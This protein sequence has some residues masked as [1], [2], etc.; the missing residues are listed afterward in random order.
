MSP[1][2][3]RPPLPPGR[4]VDLPGRGTTFVRDQA[5]PPGAPT[6]LLLHGWTASA[7]LNWCTAYP[8]LGRRWRVVALDHRGHGRG[9]R[10]Q[11][12]FTL[13]DCADDAAALVAAMGL[14]R[15][16]AV[17]YSMGG[18]VAQLLWRRHPDL[19]EGLVLCSTSAHFSETSRERVLFSVLGAT[20][21]IARVTSDARRARIA[22]RFMEGRAGASILREW[23]VAELQ[24]HDWLR[25]VEAGRAIGRFSSREWVASIDVPTSVLVTTQDTVVP[26]P[27]QLELAAAIPRT[28]LHTIDAD[29]GVCLRRPQLFV[30]ALVA[31]VASVAA[32]PSSRPLASAA[33]SNSPPS[34][35][36]DAPV[37]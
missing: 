15:V 18:A 20:S 37:T 32:Q 36:N 23:A 17:G 6:I 7:D 8:A 14:G 9:V 28:S 1:T 22:M 33:I 26:T 2:A 31:A 21:R 12:M 11:E 5:G 29:H 27:R 24:A 25:I 30:P 3:V 13:E 10:S 19:V 34:T 16:V 4:A 35:T